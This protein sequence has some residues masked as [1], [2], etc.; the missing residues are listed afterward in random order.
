MQQ[1]SVYSNEPKT[2]QLIRTTLYSEKLTVTQWFKTILNNSK[3]RYHIHKIS[4]SYHSSSHFI[5]THYFIKLFHTKFQNRA[6]KHL[7][8]KLSIPKQ[9]FKNIE[10]CDSAIEFSLINYLAQSIKRKISN[11]IGSCRADSSGCDA[12]GVSLPPFACW[13]CGFESSQEHEC[14]SQVSIIYCQVVSASG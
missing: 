12:Q 1:N 14:L 8:I 7:H 9:N 4:I 3:I 5:V 13:D 2:F 11:C 6:T 10:Y